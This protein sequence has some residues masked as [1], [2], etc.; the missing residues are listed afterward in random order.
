MKFTATV[1]VI[2]ER[3]N[4]KRSF[5]MTVYVDGQPQPVGNCTVPANRELP[6]VGQFVE[7]LYLYAFKGGA[8]F[9]PR[10]VALRDDLALPD[11]VSQPPLKYKAEGE[12][13]E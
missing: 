1:T 11:V 12:E 2:V 8:L 5:S 4:A 13:V 10:Y 6:T 3:V 9:Q 7:V